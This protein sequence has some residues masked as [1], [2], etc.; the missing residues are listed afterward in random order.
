MPN[1]VLGKV[2]VTPKGTWS[3]G[4][5]YEQLDIV[6]YGGASYLAVQN[7]PSGTALSNTSYWLC[8][9]EKGDKG[10]T[11]EITGASASISGG[12]GTPGVSVTPG[13]TSTERTFAFAFTNLKG[14]GISS[15]NI[16]KTG[17]S[18]NVDTYTITA[19]L[20]SG[21]TE[22]LE[23]TVT[24]G[25]VT[26]V[27]GRTGAV[28]GLAEQDGYYEDMSVGSAEQ[29]ISSVYVN[30]SEPYIFR[31]SGG[32][33]DI[34]D[35]DFEDAIVGGTVAWNQLI[36]NTVS[37]ST[38]KNG[39]TVAYNDGVY[40]LSGTATEDTSINIGTADKTFANHVYF[41]NCLFGSSSTYFLFG[42]GDAS[43]RSYLTQI[44]KAS[45]DAPN[46]TCTLSVLN[47]VNVDGV[48]FSVGLHDLTQIFGST[49][50]DYIYTVETGTAGE[51]V[52]LAKA[53]GNIVK[54]YY[55]YNAGTLIHVNASSHNTTGFN[56]WD[57]EWEVGDINATTGENKTGSYV[58]AKNLIPVFPNTT[59]YFKCP[60]NAYWYKYDAS[61]GYL[62]YAGP[63]T[64]NNVTI[65]KDTYYIRFVLAS[66]YGTTYKND[67]CLNIKWD[68]ERNGEYEPYVKHEYALDSSLT[69]RGIPKLDVNNRLYY[70]GDEYANDGTV[71]RRYGIVD[72]GG[73]GMSWSYSS[74]YGTMLCDTITDIKYESASVVANII[75][76]KYVAETA[77]HLNDS[78]YDKAVAISGSMSRIIVKDTTY[79]DATAFKTAM[80]GV[81]LVY[82]LATPTTESADAYTSPQIID[83]FGTEEFVVTEQSGVA[84]PVGHISRYTNNLRAKLE[85]APES[86]SGGNGKYVVQ[87]TSGINTY[88]P[89]VIDSVLPSAPSADG[90][91]V[92][93]VTVS[94]GTESYS[95]V[96]E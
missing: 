8:L 12:Y 25:S 30:D 13:G 88:V 61:G 78:A 50:A 9:A 1:T 72:L 95:W 41:R 36:Q 54:P 71:T 10:D 37:T 19:T 45:V 79:T 44:G 33:A 80:S 22:S 35:R 86:P 23:F 18:G 52:A 82:E 34:G 42:I 89:L 93:K 75:C 65:P 55:P 20:T 32:S 74:T 56:Q 40:S 70:D 21:D 3:A 94:G 29:L 16:A 38:T 85:M 66:T 48:K 83:D 6:A 64:N 24:N 90:T 14:N 51:G 62:G 69:L 17:T 73:Q 28:T 31:T 4:T 81:Y 76:S 60:V 63:Y 39:V 47:G 59:Y 58:R 11:G 49:I 87:Q 43:K 2:M 67:V 84:M 77:F 27:N 15:M 57:E 96:Q 91:Y 5:A 68:G 46:S 92:L 53:W 26:S 7:V